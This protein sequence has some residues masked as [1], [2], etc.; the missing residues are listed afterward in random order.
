MS[1][2]PNDH[3]SNGGDNSTP[4]TNINDRVG[5]QELLE[6]YLNDRKD[7]MNGQ[8]PRSHKS[9]LSFFVEWFNEQTDYTYVDEITRTDILRFK[10]WR[11]TDHAPITVKTQMDTLRQL[12]VWG[13]NKGLLPQDIHVAAESPDTDDDDDIAHRYIDPDRLQSNLEWLK[14]YEWGQR[15]TVVLAL[16]WETAMRRSSVRALDVEDWDADEQVLHLRSRPD[17][18]TRLK[19]GGD[20]ERDVAITDRTAELID[21]WIDGPRP[22]VI[23]ESGREPLITTDNGRVSAGCIQTDVYDAVRPE[24]VGDECS[25]DP[26]QG[27]CRANGKA[28][29]Y[30]CEDSEGPHAVRATSITYH[31]NQGWPIEYVSDRTNCS[32]KTIEKHYDEAT[33]AEKLERRRDFIDEL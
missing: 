25:C 18:E 17:T 7:E 29:A 6:L 12:L 27:T 10:K 11:F 32:E 20:S 5:A 30:R 24:R 8:T 1:S 28:D 31:L 16:I 3:G 23:D 14:T 2:K 13:E 4:T 21:A 33:K 9:R 15:Q 19:N 26:P 22:E